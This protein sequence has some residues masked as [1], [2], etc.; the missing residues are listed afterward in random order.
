MPLSMHETVIA[1]SIIE[2]ANRHGDVEAIS[3]EIGELAPVPEHELVACLREL[4]GWK[5]ES[6]EKTAV[7]KCACGFE[8]RPIILEKSHDAVLF[9]CRKCEETPSIISG[10]EIMISK[11]TVK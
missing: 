7:V 8:G 10:N 5:I 2:E 4:T 11:V 3:L 6:K 1:R 9:E